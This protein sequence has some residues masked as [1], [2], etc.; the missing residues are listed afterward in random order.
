LNPWAEIFYEE[1]W[2]NSIAHHL[3]SIEG[4]N[5]QDVL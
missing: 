2:K 5:L 4:W 1:F 3:L